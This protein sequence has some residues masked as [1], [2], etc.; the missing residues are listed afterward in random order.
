ML[1]DN[2]TRMLRAIL[3]NSWRQHPA[4]QQLYGLLPPIMKTTQVRRSRDQ[5]ISNILLFMDEQRQ[6][7]LLEPT[8]NSVLRQAVALK[9]YRERWTIDT[10]LI[11]KSHG[12]VHQALTIVE[13]VRFITWCQRCHFLVECIGAKVIFRN[14][15]RV[16]ATAQC[17]DPPYKR[18]FATLAHL[19]G[20]ATNTVISHLDYISSQ[21]KA[22]LFI[23]YHINHWK[24]FNAKSSF[25]KYI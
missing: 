11:L 8:Y 1:D 22:R 20:R 19:V 17:S 9:T 21:G 23:L 10:N 3:N 4:K 18:P 14:V 13:W 12:A 6:G 25:Y 16:S 5:P 2:Y 24:I 7:N 15:K